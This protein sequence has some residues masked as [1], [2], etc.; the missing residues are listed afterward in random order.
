[1]IFGYFT[2]AVALAISAVAAYYSIVGL[3][4]I[5]AAAVLPIVIMGVMLEIGKVTA[6]VWL[7]LNWHRAGLAYK[8]YLVPAVGI[9]MLLTSMGIFGFLSKSHLDQAVPSSNVTAQVA[10]LDEK[11]SLEKENIDVARKAL[12][13]LDKTIDETIARSTSEEAVIRAANL[14]RSQQAERRRLQGDIANAQNNISRYTA[15]RQPLAVQLRAIEAEVGPIKYIAALIYG[16][17]IDNNL[18]ERAVRIVIIIIV[19]VFDPLALILIIAAQQSLRW[20]KSE[21]Q[22][23]DVQIIPILS[24]QAEIKEPEPEAKSEPI[25]EEKPTEESTPEKVFDP[26]KFPYLDKFDHFKNIKPVVWVEEKST[27]TETTVN[28][29]EAT[30]SITKIPETAERY[31]APLPVVPET[32]NVRKV[33]PTVVED[34]KVKTDFGTSFPVNANKGDTFL[35]VDYNPNKLYKYNG[36]KWMEIDKSRSDSYSYDEKYIDFLIEK[37]SSGEYDIE[38][39]SSLEQDL[40]AE[41]LKRNNEHT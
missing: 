12:Q 4:A 13:Q 27:P 31:K 19:A 7:K 39:L 5:F 29:V 10:L 8:L 2:L 37:I 30:K 35:R 17:D 36:V 1:M 40:I 34:I 14:R 9:L 16:D 26:V 25:I 23:P 20:A 33:K 32:L 11:I 6:A 41:K 22:T 28:T 38:Q 24:Q 3:T 15:E 18:L 21:S